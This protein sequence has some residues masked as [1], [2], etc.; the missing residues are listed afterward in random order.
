MANIISNYLNNNSIYS[1]FTSSAKQADS[2]S[3]VTPVKKVAPVDSNA[4]AIYVKSAEEPEKKATYS[5]NKMSKEDRA[6][7]VEQLKADQAYRQQ[8]LTD[9]V[10][11]TLTGQ[12]KSFSMATDSD[13]FWRMF[14]DGKVTVD[15]AAKAKAQEDIS[16]DGYWGVKQTS[17]RLFDFASALAGD[18]VEMME[19]MQKAM[20]KGFGQA[21]KTWGKELPSISKDTYDAAN[22]LFEEY[23]A[24]KKQVEE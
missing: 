6:A 24:S 15:A 5:I 21:T 7:I 11:K 14:A 13:E 18:N 3:K 22:K 20:D 16:E 23:Y 2:V 12:S 19:K 9:I 1:T 4:A 8:Q 17:E 10:S